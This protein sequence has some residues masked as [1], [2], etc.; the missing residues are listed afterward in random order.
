MSEGDALAE[1]IFLGFDKAN[2]NFLIVGGLVG[3]LEFLSWS[4]SF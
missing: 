4:V 2:A 1:P 3:C